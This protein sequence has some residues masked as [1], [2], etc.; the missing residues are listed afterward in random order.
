LIYVDLHPGAVT[1]SRPAPERPS[2]RLFSRS[3]GRSG[4]N[5]AGAIAVLLLLGATAFFLPALVSPLPSAG[6]RSVGYSPDGSILSTST[7][8]SGG[9]PA[10]QAIRSGAYGPYDEVGSVPVGTT[11]LFAAYDSRNGY[12]YVTDSGSNQV[13][14]VDGLRLLRNVTVGSGAW[15]PLY[16]SKNGNVYVTV[17]FADQV[18]VIHGTSVIARIS[19]PG[20]FYETYDP[21]NGWVYVLDAASNSNIVSVINGTSLVGTVYA[22]QSPYGGAYDPADQDVYIANVNSDNVSVVR[23]LTVVASVGVGQCPEFPVF[24]P[25]SEEM[26]VS[27]LCSNNLTILNGTT[28]AGNVRAGDT[29]WS[30]VYNARNGIVYVPDAG[31]Q[32]VTAVNGSRVLRTIHLGYTPDSLVYVPPRGEVLAL[33]A[34]GDN[35]SILGRDSVVGSVPTGDDPHSAIYDSADGYV[36]VVNSGS[37]NLSV[38]P[39]RDTWPPTI[40]FVTDL[41]PVSG[42]LGARW[43]PSSP[44][45]APPASSCRGGP[46]TST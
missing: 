39:V 35:L 26:Y 40:E 45:Q 29:P 2:P 43:C 6:P 44:V 37:D 8:R 32:T 5:A 24:D 18:A 25:G 27:N 17:Q 22:G 11:P 4:R 31:A 46:R 10:P 34:Y 21:E 14:V 1:E 36:Y 20:A 33:N 28:V 13:S 42:P 16:D 12:V 38:I 30:P 3:K 41:P 9:P 19:V 15:Y 23:G 7:P